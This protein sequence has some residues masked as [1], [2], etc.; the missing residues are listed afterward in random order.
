MFEDGKV[1]FSISDTPPGEAVAIRTEAVPLERDA[2][3]S[4]I[5]LG[6]DLS[7]HNPA[8][9]ERSSLVIQGDRLALRTLAGWEDILQG[10]QTA[11]RAQAVAQA[12]KLKLELG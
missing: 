8:L 1:R 5:R 6:C 9:L 12:L 4:A 10:E 11:R 3:G 2:L 7:G